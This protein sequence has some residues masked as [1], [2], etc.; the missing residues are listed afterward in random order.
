MKNI[1]NKN[2]LP[3][4]YGYIYI[5]TNKING[6]RY[7]GKKAFDKYLHWCNYLGSGITLKRAIKKYGNENFDTKIIEYCFN[8]QDACIKEQYWIEQYN[9]VQ[10]SDFYNIAQGG[11]GGNTI[12]GYTN[13]Q[14]LQLSQKLSRQRKGKINLGAK[15]GVARK[16]ICLNTMKV[17]D[18]IVNA[19][20][21]YNISKDA[22]QQCCS[23]SFPS[24]KTVTS[25][26]GEKL[27]FE[28]Y[29]ENK[30]YQYVPYERQYP[31]KAIHC[32]TNNK[33][34]NTIHEAVKDTQCSINSIRY[35]CK[36]HIRATRNGM[37]FE[38][39]N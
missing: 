14:K 12:G 9:A 26:S 33:I 30:E 31:H 39:V 13:E 16:V 38:Y 17:F 34:Y 23:D 29:D 8:E 21:E 18:A 37:Q 1:P 2:M 10:S 4:P 20:K 7:I 15:N 6:K 36:N 11:D 32:I 28:Y 22:I 35:C 24:H 27:Q 19:A 25:P 5:T 3:L